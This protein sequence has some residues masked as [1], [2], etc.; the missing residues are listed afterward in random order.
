MWARFRGR[1]VHLGMLGIGWQWWV[2]FSGGARLGVLGHGGKSVCPGASGHGC[3]E[4]WVITAGLVS[5]QLGW[6]SGGT[7]SGT[8]GSDGRTLNPGSLSQSD[9]A[10]CAMSRQ[11][12]QSST[13]TGFACQ[14]RTSG[15]CLWAGTR[16]GSVTGNPRAMVQAQQV[17]TSGPCVWGCLIPAVCLWPRVTGSWLLPADSSVIPLGTSVSSAAILYTYSMLSL[18]KSLIWSEIELYIKDHFL[19]LVSKPLAIFPPHTYPHQM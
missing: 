5:R 8:M 12:D 13:G 17:A 2:L 7:G 3:R 14:V 19:H 15:R 6:S 11:R 10:R 9:R 16:L 1:F 18:K 4:H